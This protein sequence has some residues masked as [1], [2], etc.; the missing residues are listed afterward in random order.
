MVGPALAYAE[1]LIAELTREPAD[2]VVGSEMLFGVALGCEAI[3]QK[4][5]ILSANISLYPLPGVPPLGPGLLP[6][7]TPEEHAMHEAVAQGLSDMLDSQL[8]VLNSARAQLGLAPLS[9]VLDQLNAA[10]AILLGTSRA[11]DFAPATLPAKV[12]YVGPQLDQPAWADRSTGIDLADQRPLILVAFSTTFQGHVEVLQ[13][14]I[15]SVSRMPVRAVVTLGDTI[16]P[17]ELRAPDNVR[18]VHSASHD[19]LMN[20]AA[21]LI[22]HGGHGTVTRGLIHE[23]PMLVIP[24]GRDQNDNA[25]RVTSR[26]AGLM[27]PNGASEDEIETAVLQLLSDARFRENARKLGRAVAHDAANSPVV[28]ELEGLAQSNEYACADV[29]LPVAC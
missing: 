6:A 9:N 14:V 19:E 20:E 1:D 27:L 2:L 17:G 4:L 28:S 12:R 16:F 7:Q 18:L 24:H 10:S 22:T 25:A 26:G 15:N 21:L 11:F 5:A 8:P 3:G 13:R 29:Q 23:L